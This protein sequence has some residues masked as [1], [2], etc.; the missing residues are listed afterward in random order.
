MSDK[1]DPTDLAWWRSKLLRGAQNHR[2]GGPRGFGPISAQHA[3]QILD[4]IAEA[5]LF[6]VE[7]KDLSTLARLVGLR[8]KFLPRAVAMLAR[9]GV[10]RLTLGPTLRLEL[11]HDLL[12]RR[13]NSAQS[14]PRRHVSRTVRER[15]LRDDGFRCGHCGR[16]LKPARLEVGHIVPVSVLGADA[17]AN[18]VALC[19]PHNR[20]AWDA[21]DPEFLRLYR[22]QRVQKPVGVRF[23]DG[24]FWPVVN[25][26]LRRDR[27]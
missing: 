7:V 16:V 12:A 25:G 22:G 13:K 23:R 9:S 5:P 8:S 10:V 4:H 20:A 15:V 6:R 24:L 11:R 17:P 1:I 19:K 26:R 14:T 2:D 18:C 3:L 27:Q 21:F